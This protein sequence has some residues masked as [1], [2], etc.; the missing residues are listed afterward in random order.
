MARKKIDCGG[1]LAH[2][3]RERQV[4][5]SK[6]AKGSTRTVK[7][8]AARIVVCCPKGKFRRGRCT[9]GMHAQSILRPF[10]N[11]KCARC[12]VR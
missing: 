5:P 10:S 6:C 8:G 3:C 2:F 1:P 11:P 7:R 4:S 9:V 12:R